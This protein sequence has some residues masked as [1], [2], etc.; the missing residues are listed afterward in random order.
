MRRFLALVA[1][2]AV[3]LA[4]CS[5]GD[6]DGGSDTSSPSDETSEQT[7]DTSA[8][9]DT[10]DD[11]GE[12]DECTLLE[13]SEIEAEFGGPV[14]DPM[15]Q[16][17]QCQWEVGEDQS[18][19]GTGTISVFTGTEIPGESG[20]ERYDSLLDAATDPVEVDGVGDAAFY[21]PVFGSVTLLANDTVVTVQAAF[22]PEPD[23]QQEKVES[24]AGDM[25]DRL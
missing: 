25:A 20:Q 6:D 18:Q 22:L 5:S 23:G 7:G 16:G 24:L 9:E 19:P 8:T 15:D 17:Y 14:S 21:E 4:A 10:G 12:L 13:T 3:L 11:G 2:C 1:T